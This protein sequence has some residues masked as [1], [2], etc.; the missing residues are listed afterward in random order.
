[1]SKSKRKPYWRDPG[2]RTQW[3]DP[4]IYAG[5][6]AAQ[7]FTAAANES[8]GRNDPGCN[9][10]RKQSNSLKECLYRQ[11]APKN[12]KIIEVGCG[13]GGDLGKAERAGVREVIGIDFSYGALKEAVTRHNKT[14]S[15]VQAR[16][17]LHDFRSLFSFKHGTA[18]AVSVMFALHYANPVDFGQFLNRARP[19]VVFGVVP[20][21]SVIMKH[22]ISQTVA[23]FANNPSLKIKGEADAATYQ[24]SLGSLIQDVQEPLWCWNRI[25]A[26]LEQNGYYLHYLSPC[27]DPNN[28]G[29]AMYSSFALI[30][31]QFPSN[32]IFLQKYNEHFSGQSEYC[33][34]PKPHGGDWAISGSE[35]RG[36]KRWKY[37]RA[38]TPGAG[39]SV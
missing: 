35:G 18:D 28:V 20:N 33:D 29:M 2:G 11:F 38:V 8:H 25:E 34:K 36:K 17:F 7:V 16:F 32:S 6:N 30:R 9:D 1:M 39:N 15:K 10:L 26:V 21:Y 14:Y 4:E 12:G 13:R 5:E 37:G 22:L 24:F 23:P 3:D 31:V 27:A 19:Q